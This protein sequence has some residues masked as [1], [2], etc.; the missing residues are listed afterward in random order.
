M[1]F[2]GRMSHDAILASDGGSTNRGGF[3]P[4]IRSATGK[5]SSHSMH[6]PARL[7]ASPTAPF[8]MASTCPAAMSAT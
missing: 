6:G 7:Y 3:T 5:T 4:V 8:S 1:A 2:T